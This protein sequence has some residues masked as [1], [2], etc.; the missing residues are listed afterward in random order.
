MSFWFFQ[1][2]R[3]M[4]LVRSNRMSSMLSRSLQEQFQ[5][6][7]IN[8]FHQC[9]VLLHSF[10]SRSWRRDYPHR[11]NVPRG[12]DTL[13]T[14][15]DFVN[16][17]NIRINRIFYQYASI[18]CFWG[19]S[20]DFCSRSLIRSIVLRIQHDIASSLGTHRWSDQSYE[21]AADWPWIR[22]VMCA[23][24]GITP[25]IWSL[26][27][28]APPKNATPTSKSDSHIPNCLVICLVISDIVE[29]DGTQWS[30]SW[31]N[32]GHPRQKLL[33]KMSDPLKCKGSWLGTESSPRHQ[34]IHITPSSFYP[35]PSSQSLTGHGHSLTIPFNTPLTLS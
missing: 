28:P 22:D 8:H 9:K 10:L 34:Y 20:Y 21:I 4:R 35:S 18:F 17:P 19:N 27:K 6:G 7:Y 15:N 31:W 12:I 13:H 16:Y 2:V 5:I 14:S 24:L 3:F 30:W 29:L 23:E 1:C 26:Q 33:W 32:N 11:P 25:P